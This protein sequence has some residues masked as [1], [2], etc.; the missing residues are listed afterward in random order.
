MKKIA[1]VCAV[2]LTV[3]GCNTNN[4]GDRTLAGAG[5]GAATGAA[6]G[7]AGGDRNDAVRGA[8]I[9][10]LAGGILGRATAPKNCTAYD[11]NG[12]PYAVA[13]P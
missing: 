6:I 1:L 12:R 4:K 11:R 13:C 5:L 10:G 2:L 8:L 9:G 3:A 7:A